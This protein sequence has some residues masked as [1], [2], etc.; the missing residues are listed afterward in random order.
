[1]LG[2]GSYAYDWK[3]NDNRAAPTLNYQSAIIQAKESRDPKDSSVASI[4]IDPK[5]LNPYYRYF[6]DAGAEHVVWMMDA[7]TA[8]NQWQ[9]AK[10]YSPRGVSVW[11]LGAED[12]GVWSVIGRTHITQDV[13]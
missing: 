7:T 5:T 3:R 11:C 12:P 2:F 10:T 1:I 13:G 9:V 8:F 4:R 6:D